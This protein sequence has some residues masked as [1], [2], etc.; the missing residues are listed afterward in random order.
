MP[1]IHTSDI[2]VLFQLLV[3]ENQNIVIY[4]IDNQVVE[5]SKH[6]YKIINSIQNLDKNANL[7]LLSK[8]DGN[9]DFLFNKCIDF[10]NNSFSNYSIFDYQYFNNPN[11]TMRWVYPKSLKYPSF[12]TLYNAS[13]M[14]S[15]LIRLAF[16]NAFRFGLKSKLNSGDF[17][18]ITNGE[19]AVETLVKEARG[20]A[21]SIFTGTVGENRKAIIEVNRNR[22]TTHFIKVPLG[23]KSVKLV[24]KEKYNLQIL[25][26]YNFKKSILPK[27]TP[28]QNPKVA[29]I[30]NVQPLE[31]FA[32][33]NDL[34]DVHLNVLEEWYDK[35]IQTKNISELTEF[36][37]IKNNLAELSTYPKPQN[38]LS[39]ETV[40][41]LIDGLQLWMNTIDESQKIAVGMAHYDFT[42]WNMYWTKSRLHVYDW[43]LSKSDLPLLYDAFHFIFQASIL[44]KRSTFEEIQAQIETLKNSN[45]VKKLNENPDFDFDTNY[46][47]YVLSVASYYL[48]LYLKQ[49][50]LHEQAH[51]LVN[52]WLLA[53]DN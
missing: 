1:K 30:S 29:I 9:I 26:K 14:K 12:L 35:T 43:E 53:I 41:R 21:Y 47:F 42:P 13:G 22:K 18:L 38:D 52:T 8:I 45:L 46:R 7:I 2:A 36:Q 19:N 48:N 49:S 24:E 20:E 51:W 3:N 27:V 6:D 25:E 32:T 34:T 39:I 5:N 50:P 11:A 4:D 40:K 23:E 28:S 31:S 15:K 33:L 17:R 37:L 10:S 44:V 16:Q